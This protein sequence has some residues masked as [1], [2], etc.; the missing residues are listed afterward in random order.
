MTLLSDDFERTYL[1][2]KADPGITAARR[3]ARPAFQKVAQDQHDDVY[4]PI[5]RR[6]TGQKAVSFRKA[7]T[8]PR[9]RASLPTFAAA[10]RRPTFRASRPPTRS[11]SGRL[12]PLAGHSRPVGNPNFRLEYELYNAT[13]QKFQANLP[14]T[15][16]T[17]LPYNLPPASPAPS[18]K[19]RRKISA[20]A[21]SSTAPRRRD[22]SHPASRS[23]PSASTLV[24]ASST[25]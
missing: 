5:L 16:S 12:P 15:E 10:G 9:P 14:A 13:I 22:G 11:I 4:C 24:K 20:A 18:S 25:T 2:P 7:L 17:P 6:K 19:N 1:C 8:K 3:F 23:S 21:T